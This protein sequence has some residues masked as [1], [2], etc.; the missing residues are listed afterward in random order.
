MRPVA[1]SLL[2]T[3]RDA[4]IKAEMDHQG[5]SMKS[6]FKLADKMHAEMVAVVGPDELANGQV[7]LRNMSTHEEKLVELANVVSEL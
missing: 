3:V 7:K 6:Q 4:G 5:R 2:Q 1:F